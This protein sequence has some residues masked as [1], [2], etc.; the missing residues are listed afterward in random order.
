MNKEI[1]TYR[2]KF[3]IQLVLIFS[4][5]LI[6]ASALLYYYINFFWYV[7]SVVLDIFIIA[8]IYVS[9]K[10]AK[11]RTEDNKDNKIYRVQE[12]PL[13]PSFSSWA[14]FLIIMSIIIW[15]ALNNRPLSNSMNE[16]LKS[17][18]IAPLLIYIIIS[19]Y[20]VSSLNQQ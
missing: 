6:S 3:I 15:F 1:T 13:L 5:W 20:I 7:N 18:L 17:L 11:Y 14:A 4:M 2:K 12:D 9:Y 10:Y 19:V 8:I 16:L